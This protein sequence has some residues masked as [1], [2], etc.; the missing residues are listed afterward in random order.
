M[1]AKIDYI[2]FTLPAR[3]SGAGHSEETYEHIATVL[4]D[5]GLGWFVTELGKLDVSMR[6]GRAHYGAG[7]YFQEHHISLWFG[8]IANHILI[9]IA[10]VGCQW[11]RDTSTI[12]MLIATIH[13]RV[14]RIDVA[15]DF[16][17]DAKP[18]DFVS[19]M[20]GKRFSSRTSIESATGWTEYVGSMKSSRYAR[21]YVYA[22]PH[23]RAGI[24]R[25]EHV[26]RDENA[27]A[28]AAEIIARSLKDVV[29][30]LGNTFGWQHEIWK[31]L[32]TTEGK[33]RAKR[34]DTHGSGTLIWLEKAVKPALIKAHQSGLIDMRELLQRWLDEASLSNDNP[35]PRY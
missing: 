15:V 29:S 30:D 10:G 11:L 16:R 20:K 14:T 27:K 32:Q 22:E 9:E 33:L 18:T 17:T 26:L 8:G 25:V 28:A 2:S 3:L 24:L 23:P 6:S 12:E 5:A 35:L 21:V 7:M 19:K 13:N 34:H 1:D 31:P 4:D